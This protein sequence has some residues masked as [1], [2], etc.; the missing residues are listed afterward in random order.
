MNFQGLGKVETADW[1]IDVAFRAATKKAGIM[2]AAASGT[3]LDKSKSIELAKLTELHAVL[4][5]HLMQI[6]LSFPSIDGLPE[7]YQ[8]LVRTMLEYDKLKKSLGA[9]NWAVDKIDM[10]H[11]DYMRDLTRTRD[12]TR[13]NALRKEYYGRVSSVVKTIKEQL[14]Y[15]ENSRKVMKEFP[16]IKQNMFTV[17]I[18]GFPNIGKTTLLSKL[19]GSKPEIAAYA[20]TTKKLNVGYL[21][22]DHEKVQVID[23]PG[24]LNRFDKM[25]AIEQQ[26]HLA[27]K[28]CADLIVY[29]FDLSEPF[30]LM[31]QKKLFS[32]LKHLHKPIIVYVSKTDLLDKKLVAS[33]VT[34]FKENI[35]TS[36]DKLAAEIVKLSRN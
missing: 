13:V 22:S 19:T 17:C 23:T 29:I 9:V 1:Y 3:R 10:L 34:N 4:R 21:K 36:S 30:P 7:F 16:S 28:Y 24:T 26:A 6:L 31:D 25:N 11:R 18:A 35:F 12:L 8:Q 15:L 5:K 2:R 32:Q 27:M 33:F 20:F 14:A